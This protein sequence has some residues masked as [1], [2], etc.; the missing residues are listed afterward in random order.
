MHVQYNKCLRQGSLAVS[1]KD[2]KAHCYISNRK[3]TTLCCQGCLDVRERSLLVGQ[4]QAAAGEGPEAGQVGRL[5][6]RRGGQ[7]H[8][9]SKVQWGWNGY[10]VIWDL[11][12]LIFLF[13]PNICVL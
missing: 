8:P 11:M 1:L 12:L 6:A 10:H 7:A 13:Y 2:G 5:S 4:H 3:I 9:V